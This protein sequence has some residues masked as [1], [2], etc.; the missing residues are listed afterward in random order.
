MELSNI[1]INITFNFLIC[2]C[3]TAKQWDWRH[4]IKISNGVKKNIEK[5]VP[6][7]ITNQLSIYASSRI[8]HSLGKVG[9]I[10]QGVEKQAC[11]Y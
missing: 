6:E 11:S 10:W 1:P 7:D 5:V 8:I 4:H 9:T 3:I 2:T